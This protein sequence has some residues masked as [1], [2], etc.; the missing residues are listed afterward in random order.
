MSSI[1]PVRSAAAARR[2]SA[3]AALA[4]WGAAVWLLAVAA[5]PARAIPAFSRQ[6]RLECGSCHTVI[7]QLTPLGEQFRSAGFRL[8]PELQA[9]SRK[10]REP[11]YKA[12]LTPDLALAE[13]LFGRSPFSLRLS[14][15][16][17]HQSTA[18]PQTRLLWDELLLNAGAGH[19]RWSYFLHQHIHKGGA[20]GKEQYAA[21]LQAND[22]IRAGKHSASLQAGL[23]ELELGLSPHMSRVSSLG[24]LPYA[25]SIGTDG[26]FTLA[27][28]QLGVQLRG[29]V[30]PTWR[31]A[32]AL[33]TGSGLRTENNGA[34]D[35]YARLAREPAAGPALG[36]FAYT[37]RRELRSAQGSYQ[38]DVLRVG[39]DGRWRP[40]AVSDLHL[41][42]IL[43]WG[44]DNR[45]F[46]AGRFREA[47]SL[48]GSLGAD[49]MLT[50]ATLFHGRLEW[51]RTNL[52]DNQQDSFRPVAGIHWLPQP[53]FRVTL[54]GALS[55]RRR[56]RDDVQ[57]FLGGMWAF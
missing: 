38:N 39:V 19:R 12:A 47:A 40:A 1:Y 28:P 15:D 21:W 52:P 33:V 16:L 18:D 53:N 8:P 36:L 27:E 34:K 46:T 23:F 50:R 31:Y 25:T 37:G 43:V 10:D 48:S 44:S 51:L 22:V 45:V 32:V 49:Y 7:P 41:F 54:E 57:L 26:N 13:R 9:S 5:P 30:D 11:E 3:I 24:Y 14:G 42:G 29:Q 4:F 55:T 35:L 17:R 56:Q 20:G 6:H 2:A